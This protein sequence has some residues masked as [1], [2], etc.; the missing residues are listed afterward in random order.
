VENEGTKESVP[1]S[2]SND[3]EIPC[4]ESMKRREYWGGPTQLEDFTS[5]PSGLGVSWL[6]HTKRGTI[7]LDNSFSRF[8]TSGFFLGTFKGTSLSSEGAKYERV[9]WQNH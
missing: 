2:L 1:L 5:G 4:P 9:M 6:L 8:D 3:H 7:S